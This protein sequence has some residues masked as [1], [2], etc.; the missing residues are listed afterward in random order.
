VRAAAA[1]R[2]RN[3]T[4]RAK[5]ALLAAIAAEKSGRARRRMVEALGE[6]RRDRG[7]IPELK[8]DRRTR[9]PATIVR[10]AAL[11]SLAQIDAAGEYEYLKGK[12]AVNS[13]HQVIRRTVFTIWGDHDDGGRSRC[14]STP[15]L[16][17]AT[18]RRGA[19]P[20]TC[21]ARWA[22]T[23]RQGPAAENPRTADRDDRRPAFRTR[24]AAM[25][26][27]GTLGR[28]GSHPSASRR[29]ATAHVGRPAETGAGRCS[30]RRTTAAYKEE[31]EAGEA[32]PKSVGRPQGTTRTS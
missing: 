12:T 8:K 18:P 24:S 7:L 16:P 11:E 20:P 3:T 30:L 27:L 19:S 22:R 5:P 25:D 6:Y 29:G 32:A 23:S 14:C 26:A 31:G 17:G 21:S 9:T 10:A 28:P 2:W 1:R 13:H 4:T 15:R